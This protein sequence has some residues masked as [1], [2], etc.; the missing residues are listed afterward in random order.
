MQRRTSRGWRRALLL[1]SLLIVFLLLFASA[2]PIPPPGA[3]RASVSS[4][5]PRTILDTDINPYG[6]NF[7][8][9]HEAEPWKI[10]KTFQMAREAG[11]GWAKQH[12]PWEELELRKD[13][14][15]DDRLNKST[16]EKYDRIVDEALKNN[17]QVIARLDRPPAWTRVDNSVPERP[18][19][20]FED[21][22][23]FVHAVVSHF[24]GRVYYY[25]IWNEPN[26]YPEW[27][28]QSIDAA[29]YTRLLEIAYR[30]AKEADPNVRILSAPLAQTLETNTRN[31]SELVFLNQMY[32][33]GAQNSFD[34]LFANGYGFDRPPDDA[35]DPNVL[36]FARVTLVREIMERHGDGGKPIWFNEFGWNASPDSLPRDKLLWGQVTEQQ[37]ADYTAQAIRLARERWPW[38]GVFNIWYFRQAGQISPERADYYFR[39]VDTGFTPRLVYGTI[40]KATES[41]GISGPGIYQASNPAVIYQGNWALNFRPDGGGRILRVTQSPGASATI[42]FRGSDITLLTERGPEAGTILV[43]VDGGAANLI[44]NDRQGRS[45]IDLHAPTQEQRVEIPI[46]S[47]LG[48]GEHILRMTLAPSGVD[49]RGSSFAIDGFVVE[50]NESGLPIAPGVLLGLGLA[51]TGVSGAM[52]F[53]LRRRP[54]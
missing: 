12:F 3:T 28:D 34:I 45:S 11:I 13:R 9:H 39:M 19:D 35:P 36:N 53:V 31:L 29:G 54:G 37:Q 2:L 49:G 20:N 1:A 48:S 43:T 7:F 15:W 21:Y 22:G 4:A 32:E 14:F 27:G 38:A 26:I 6:A 18:P 10:E 17:I 42:H 41:I 16:W 8:L 44:A 5:P 30:R 40:K 25:Q 23:D 46:A 24:K 52:V 50:E 33:H 51:L 47:G